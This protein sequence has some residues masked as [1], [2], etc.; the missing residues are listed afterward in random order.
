[1]SSSRCSLVKVKEVVV[2]ARALGRALAE[3][4]I[5]D[6]LVEETAAWLDRAP[7]RMFSEHGKGNDEDGDE[8][9]KSQVS[10][11]WFHLNRALH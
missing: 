2:E 8:P 9:M 5:L 10:V 4:P 6:E 1:M 7:A 11:D 3:A